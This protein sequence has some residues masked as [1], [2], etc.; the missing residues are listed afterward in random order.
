MFILKTF[1]VSL[2][3]AICILLSHTTFGQKLQ[4]L[5]FIKLPADII[6][7]EDVSAITKINSLLVIGSDEA[8]GENE[9]ENYIQLL[10]KH[11]DEGYVLHSNILLFKGNEEDGK[12]MDIEGLAAVGNQI[13]VVGSHSSKRNKINKDKKYEQNRKKFHAN[14]IADEKNRDWL[15]RLTIDIH[16]KEVSRDKITLQNIIKNDPVLKAF[17]NIPGKENGVDIEGLSVKG[18]W[19]YIGFRTPVFRENY[20]PVMK[21]KF[22]DPENTYELLY[23]NLNGQGIR[24]MTSVSD[25]FLIVAGSVA[26]GLNSFQLYYWDGRDVIPGKDRVAGEIGKIRL[27]GGIHPPKNGKA[28]GIITIWEKSDLYNLIIVYDGVKSKNKVMQRF[29][30][31]K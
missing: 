20:V 18:E 26:A 27:L 25:G 3:P 10:T 8:G 13:Y 5:E 29:H 9:S 12:E 24:G 4:P 6:A 28:E 14:K 15:Y 7:A 30:F 2:V 16:G 1:F 23:I 31:T 19:L 17:R 11:A 22:D 21:L